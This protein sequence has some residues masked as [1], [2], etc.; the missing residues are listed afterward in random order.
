MWHYNEYPS[1]TVFQ[2]V[3][4]PP[5]NS[6]KSIRLGPLLIGTKKEADTLLAALISEST[7]EDR[8]VADL[9]TANSARDAISALR[10]LSSAID[11]YINDRSAENLTYDI[12]K[13]NVTARDVLKQHHSV[14]VVLF[15]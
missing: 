14:N 12:I 9:Q 7:A 11:T 5:A 2:F 8:G 4:F 3:E 6:G 15:S 10:Q 1:G 13:T